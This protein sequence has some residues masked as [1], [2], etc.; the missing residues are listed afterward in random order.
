MSILKKEVFVIEFNGVNFQTVFPTELNYLSEI[1]NNINSA[2]TYIKKYNNTFEVDAYFYEIHISGK[3][4]F[5]TT[6]ISS[7]ELE[8]DEVILLGYNQDKLVGDDCHFIDYIRQLDFDEWDT[9]FN[10]NKKV[11]IN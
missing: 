4:E 7:I 9:H 8:D 1:F 3:N 2:I 6:V 10:F 5:S 11:K